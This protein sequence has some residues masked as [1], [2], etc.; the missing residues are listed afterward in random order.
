MSSECLLTLC[1]ETNGIHSN[2][3]KQNSSAALSDASPS[4]PSLSQGSFSTSSNAAAE[5]MDDEQRQKRD[6]AKRREEDR[7]RR[8]V[9][10]CSRTHR[11]SSGV[12]FQCQALNQSLPFNRHTDVDYSFI[13]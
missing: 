4:P 11:S 7:K 1:R 9:R 2:M 8:E 6:I 12:S 3:T 5:P 13:N 10:H